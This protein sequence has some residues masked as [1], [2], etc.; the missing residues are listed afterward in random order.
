VLVSISA[1][2]QITVLQSCSHRRFW[3]FKKDRRTASANRSASMFSTK[4]HQ[5]PVGGVRVRLPRRDLLRQINFVASSEMGTILRCAIGKLF[6]KIIIILKL[7]LAGP[8]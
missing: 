1:F 5:V 3:D 6:L 8:K 2:Y 4:C 7:V